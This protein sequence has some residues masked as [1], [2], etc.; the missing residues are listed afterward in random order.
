[1]SPEV[2]SAIEFFG[3]RSEA[4]VPTE[5]TEEAWERYLGAVGVEHFSAREACDYAEKLGEKRSVAVPPVHMMPL[6]G[7]V[8]K[9]ADKVREQVGGPVSLKYLYRGQ[10][11]NSR[12]RG[13]RNSD[14]LYAAA[15]DLLVPPSKVA[16]VL[17]NVCY[18]LYGQLEQ[19]LEP[20]LGV[21]WD[22]LVHIGILAQHGKRTWGYR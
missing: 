5:R 6:S 3:G 1:M 21:D 17:V 13:S 15:V 2:T 8:M 11:F 16:G 12:R 9:L 18:P 10:D 19:W 14:H 22:G 20:S 4:M 7:A